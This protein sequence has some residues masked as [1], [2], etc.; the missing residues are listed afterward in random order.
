M[1]KFIDNNNINN[2]ENSLEINI[3]QNDIK[4]FS[5]EENEIRKKIN[6]LSVECKN[7]NNSSNQLMNLYKQ[8]IKTTLK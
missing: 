6:K 8:I 7:L 1:D 5:I 2:K 3:I 4:K